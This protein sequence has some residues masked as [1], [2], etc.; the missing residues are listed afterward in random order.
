M[1]LSFK[2]V[3]NLFKLGKATAKSHIRNLI[4]IAAS[5]GSL[6]VEEQ[7]LLEYAALRNNIST[8]QLKDIQRDVSKIRFEVPR[9]EEEKFFQLYDL[10]HMMSVDKNIHSEEL[11][12][13]EIF[14]IKFGYRKEIVRE[15]IE[16]IRKNIENWTGPK[17]TMQEVL[18][19]MKVYD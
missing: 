17:E 3:I 15:M 8:A 19:S 9:N 18:A 5:D 13:C 2:D 4:E 10:V 7:R 16:L 6:G 12:L 14:A 11:R 1:L